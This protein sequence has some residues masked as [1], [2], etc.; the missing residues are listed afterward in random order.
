MIRGVFLISWRASAP[1]SPF[2]FSKTQ[3]DKLPRDKR[4]RLW[5]LGK[6]ERGYLCLSLLATIFS[7][8][9]FPVF[10]LMLSTI[11]TFFY[12]EDPDELERKVPFF[13]SSFSSL[14]GREGGGGR[15]RSGCLMRA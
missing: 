3:R 8:A 14:R 9:M 5:A 7:G 12:L 2:F 1:A 15:N 11:I 6:P 10:S 4:K 13:V